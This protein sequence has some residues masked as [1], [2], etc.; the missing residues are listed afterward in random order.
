MTIND[1]SVL[2]FSLSMKIVQNISSC[3]YYLIQVI[4]CITILFCYIKYSF[5]ELFQKHL[6]CSRLSNSC[7]HNWNCIILHN[8]TIII[9]LTV[10][11]RHLYYSGAM[12]EA[13]GTFAAGMALS[14]IIGVASG[15]WMLAYL[16]YRKKKTGSHQLA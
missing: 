15:T 9:L 6:H 10:F 4:L 7:I 13:V 16:L 5:Q 2:Q 8:Y 11:F 14:G 1:I 3:G 12:K